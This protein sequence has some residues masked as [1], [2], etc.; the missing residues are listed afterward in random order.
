MNVHKAAC[1]ACNVKGASID[2]LRSAILK[3]K[4][5]DSINSFVGKFGLGK[6]FATPFFILGKCISK[7]AISVEINYAKLKFF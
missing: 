4:D 5:M 1:F 7:S 3:T 2:L 6:S